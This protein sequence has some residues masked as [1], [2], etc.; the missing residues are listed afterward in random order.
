MDA[1]VEIR[2]HVRTRKV[3]ICPRGI[4]EHRGQPQKC[5]RRCDDAW[6]HYDVEEYED[7]D[8]V[9]VAIIWT[10]IEFHQ[11]L[12]MKRAGVQP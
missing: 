8:Y 3:Y 7:E 11:D 1:D 2:S 10:K 4:S 5:G 9:V 6:N 12:C